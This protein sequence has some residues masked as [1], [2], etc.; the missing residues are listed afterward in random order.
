LEC[1]GVVRAP[2]WPNWPG[3]PVA[4][5]CHSRPED[6]KGLCGDHHHSSS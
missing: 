6:G 3:S 4:I 5:S 1:F 2:L